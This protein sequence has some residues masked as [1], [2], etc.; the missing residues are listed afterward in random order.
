MIKYFLTIIFLAG[1]SA[2]AICQQ[3]N[4]SPEEHRLFPDRNTYSLG[5]NSQF[6]IDGFLDQ[7]SFSPLE[8]LLRKGTKNN[9]AFRAR[10]KG[11][12]WNNQRNEI[13]EK[14]KTHRSQISLA[15]GHEWHRPLG[16]RFGYY[17]GGE[18]EMG[19]NNNNFTR[20]YIN[21]DTPIGDLL[22][23]RL[24]FEK[25][26]RI[27]LLPILGFTYSPL[28]YMFVSLEMRPEIF[29]EM[30]KITSNTFNAPIDTPNHY[31]TGSWGRADIKNWKF[32]FQP[33]SGIF[34]N[35]KF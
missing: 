22:V 24:D 21:F 7:S 20:N 8:I 4:A 3:G 33:Y 26:H 25:T 5:I 19:V 9:Q 10:I 31:T 34:I 13:E 1:F 15:L 28:T 32:D 16:N 30:I 11:V 27:G 23:R 14:L 35:L 2:S 12:V 6:A 17:Y 18:V 29:Y